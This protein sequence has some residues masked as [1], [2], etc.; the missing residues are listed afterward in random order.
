MALKKAICPHCGRQI[1]VN[2]TTAQ[3]ICAMCRKDFPTNQGVDAYL[4]TLMTSDCADSDRFPF[5]YTITIEREAD[6]FI[7]D[8]ITMNLMI[9]GRPTPLPNGGMI[10][11]S[12]NTKLVEIPVH[13]TDNEFTSF[14]GVFLGSSVGRDIH[15]VWSA[16]FYGKTLG[17]IQSSN[18]PTFH[19]YEKPGAMAW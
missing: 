19:L 3:S 18:N 6:A 9:N 13:I 4:A 8:R 17:R 1:M 2:D 11:F 5:D 16:E 15:L 10:R 14:E 12:A 7:G